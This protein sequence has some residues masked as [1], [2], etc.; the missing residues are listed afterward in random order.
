LIFYLILTFFIFFSYSF[1]YL[2]SFPCIAMQQALKPRV[3]LL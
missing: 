3:D 1:F 2:C